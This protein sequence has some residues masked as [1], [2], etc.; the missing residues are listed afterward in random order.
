MQ[1][2]KKNQD[3]I[4]NLVF[5]RSPQISILTL[6]SAILWQYRVI[7]ASKLRNLRF[8][9]GSPSENPNLSC[10]IIIVDCSQHLW[11]KWVWLQTKATTSR[12]FANFSPLEYACGENR[13]EYD[14]R[15][16]L[17]R[18]KIVHWDL[19]GRSPVGS[20]GYKWFGNS[21][22]TTCIWCK[23]RNSQPINF[24]LRAL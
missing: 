10:E 8:F 14:Y 7:K 6:I 24:L 3:R 5:K 1:V 16:T 12:T 17:H 9:P 4:F 20:F 15:V 2:I 22:T 23:F 19:G 13:S 21:K 11:R 18:E